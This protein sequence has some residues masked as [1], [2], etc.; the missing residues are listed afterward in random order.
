MVSTTTELNTP[1]FLKNRQQAISIPVSRKKSCII[2]VLDSYM[3]NP[4]STQTST[5]EFVIEGTCQQVEESVSKLMNIPSIA[6]YNIGK[7]AESVVNIALDGFKKSIILGSE[8]TSGMIEMMIKFYAGTSICLVHAA[9]QSSLSTL[10]NSAEELENLANSAINVV[11]KDVQSAAGAITSGLESATNGVTSLLNNIGGGINIPKVN[12]NNTFSS[13]NITVTIPDGWINELQS[14]ENNF[15]TEDQIYSTISKFLNLPAQKLSDQINTTIGKY[16]ISNNTFPSPP[17]I[18]ICSPEFPRELSSLFNRFLTIAYVG[19]WTLILGFIIALLVCLFLKNKG[20]R[21]EMRNI[22][23]FKTRV[24]KYTNTHDLFPNNQ[25]YYAN[26]EYQASVLQFKKSTTSKKRSGILL[27]KSP[28]KRKSS[29]KKEYKSNFMNLT[30]LT[31]T[32]LNPNIPDLS[33]PDYLTGEQE[34]NFIWGNKNIKNDQDIDEFDVDILDI[35]YLKNSWVLRMG[36]KCIKCFLVSEK[37]KFISRWFLHYIYH[38]G[39][40]AFFATGFITS[41]LS[42][43]QIRLV[44]TAQNK[45]IFSIANKLDG[46]IESSYDGILSN[47]SN[48]EQNYI[49]NI[50]N[51]INSFEGVINK[52]LSTL[53][54]YGPQSVNSTLNSVVEGYTNA[55]STAL[56]NTFLKD[57]VLA[58]VNCTITK[59][60]NNVQNVLTAIN[61]PASGINLPRITE[62]IE[63][64]EIDIFELAV[65]NTLGIMKT[66]SIGREIEDSDR[67]TKGVDGYTGGLVLKVSR[68]ILDFLYAELTTSLY[69]MAPWTILV[70]LGLTRV[71]VL[72]LR[73]V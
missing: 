5:F 27:C 48:F 7:G 68:A 17:N 38:P 54:I 56:N 11:I 24:L 33:N 57:P 30:D 35:Y 28:T 59:Q 73:Y 3:D 10:A 29:A 32:G 61:I 66:V 31:N 47:S 18:T 42:Y 9:V 49:S 2:K 70:F 40:I 14:F 25:S 37:Q 34:N 15:P 26:S 20:F 12:I 1:T 23:L 13:Q 16:S 62:P 69:M 43:T 51:E 36:E 52:I 65:R 53:E 55:I 67:N 50:N 21:A 63:F 22:G 64:P 71:V 4:V 8:L 41:M 19:L 60:I 45:I 72:E 39:L 58:Y 46:L 44:N 6:I